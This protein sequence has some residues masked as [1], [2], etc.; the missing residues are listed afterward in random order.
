MDKKEKEMSGKIADKETTKAEVAG[1]KSTKTTSQGEYSDAKKASIKHMKKYFG[2]ETE[3]NDENYGGMMEKMVSED[4]GPSKKKLES[5]D[6][7]NKNILAMMDSEPELSGILSDMG[8]GAKFAEALPK[9]MDLQSLSEAGEGGD[10]PNWEENRTHRMKSF[11]E[12]QSRLK[13]YDK[14]LELAGQT[15]GA[16]VA[17]KGMEEAQVNEFAQFVARLIEDASAG[18]VSKDFLQ[19]AYYAKNYESDILDAAKQAEIKAKNAK[20]EAKM[21][22]DKDFKGDG[23][24]DISTGSPESMSQGSKGN[25][26]A[27]KLSK[28]IDRQQFNLG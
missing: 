25:N 18:K 8:K 17:D 1:N 7:S 11:D 28:S 15:F 23:T 9:Y 4:Y 19:A 16:F 5:Y 2:E 24:A 26:F 14:N 13:N 27:K 12:R 6:E 3:I 10:I 20:I 21:K 22:T